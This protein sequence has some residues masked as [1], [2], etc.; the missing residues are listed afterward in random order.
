MSQHPWILEPRPR[1]SMASKS[2]WDDDL[3][4]E[5]DSPGG[6]R[7]GAA[8][9]KSGWDDWDGDDEG[10]GEESAAGTPVP[11]AVQ[12]T[13]LTRTESSISAPH[14]TPKAVDADTCPPASTRGSTSKSNKQPASRSGVLTERRMRCRPWTGKLAV[15]LCVFGGAAREGAQVLLNGKRPHALG[16]WSSRSLPS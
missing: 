16:L 6:T 5:G 12:M 3:S 14:I 11:A 15:L 10:W 7:A 9:D 1:A 13:V 4:L 2:G 8:A